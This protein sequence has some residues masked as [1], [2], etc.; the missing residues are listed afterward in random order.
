MAHA[1]GVHQIEDIPLLYRPR[2][3]QFIRLFDA[4]LIPAP[5]TEAQQG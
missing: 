5:E 1:F 3:E 2:V 4:G